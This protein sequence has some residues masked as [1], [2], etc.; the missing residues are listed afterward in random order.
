[1]KAIYFTALSS[2]IAVFGLAVNA[3]RAALLGFLALLFVFAVLGCCIPL[4]DPSNNE[5]VAP[6][7]SAA[8]P[9]TARSIPEPADRLE[10]PCEGIID[11]TANAAL[12]AADDEAFDLMVLAARAKESGEILKLLARGRVVAEK[13][14]VRVTVIASDSVSIKVRVKGGAHPGFEGWTVRDFVKRYRAPV[15]SR[16]VPYSDPFAAAPSVEP[17]A[18]TLKYPS[19]MI[20]GK[21][22][23][24]VPQ[25]LLKTADRLDGEGQADRADLI[26]RRILQ[27]YPNAPEAGQARLRLRA[28]RRTGPDR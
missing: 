24:L 13:N 18:P 2:T 14:G 5:P 20:P 9:E 25:N 11:S 8:P 27:D 23:S 7:A 1:M 22:A 4:G 28:M 12:I 10:A 6:V 19:A 17:T 26:Y 16:A 3:R 15:V 21:V